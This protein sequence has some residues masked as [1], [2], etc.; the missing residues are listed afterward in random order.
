M[1]T[2]AAPRRAGAGRFFS[3]F[4]LHAAE[5]SE[6]AALA[7][8]PGPAR[9]PGAYP[10]GTPQA[11]GGT[12]TAG[13]TARARRHFFTFSSTMNAAFLSSNA[14]G[15]AAPFPVAKHSVSFPSLSNL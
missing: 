10:G 8:A 14:F 2:G 13:G 12:G 7:P 15:R 3:A 11:T 4:P 5:P 1:L 9:A 6:P